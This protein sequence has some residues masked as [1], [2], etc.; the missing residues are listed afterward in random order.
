VLLVP[1]RPAFKPSPDQI[2]SASAAE[3]QNANRA[4]RAFGTPREKGSGCGQRRR[5]W[6]VVPE[7]INSALSTFKPALAISRFPYGNHRRDI[8]EGDEIVVGEN[9]QAPSAAVAT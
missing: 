9:R 8:Q 6:V 3:I 1:N 2:D 7:P 4:V 5:L